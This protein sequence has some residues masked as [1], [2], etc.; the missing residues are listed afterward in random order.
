MPMK[1]ASFVAAALTAV[2]VLLSS[3]AQADIFSGTNPPGFSYTV[4]PGNPPNGTFTPTITPDTYTQWVYSSDSNTDV[5][6][7]SPTGDPLTFALTQLGL[8]AG[9]LSFVGGGSC[10]TGG[11]TCS[12]GDGTYS[13]AAAS[14]FG[15]H[16]D[17]KFLVLLYPSAITSFAIAGLSNGVSNIYAWGTSAVPLPPALLLFGTALA[18]MGILGRRRKKDGLAQ[19]I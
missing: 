6:S 10:G 9:S 18:G 7:Q 1:K 3:G 17:N 12:G 4:P 5:G 13:G 14:V 16:F 11:T 8:P 2:G 15:I 19:A